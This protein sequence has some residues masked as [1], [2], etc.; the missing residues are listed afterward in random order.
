MSNWPTYLVVLQINLLLIRILVI[1]LIKEK[2]KYIFPIPS[3]ILSL[4]SL[5]IFLFQ[6]H[7]YFYAN[8]TKFNI[9][10]AKINFAMSYLTRVIQDWFKVGLN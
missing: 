1:I 10:I 3:A 2:L 5:I 8:S 9:D 4:T 6:C 7:L